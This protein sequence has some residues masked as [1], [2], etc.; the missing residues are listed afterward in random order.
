MPWCAS[1]AWPGRITP[2]PP[3]TIAAMDAVWCGAQNGG[4]VISPDPGGSR[5]ATE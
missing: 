4:V 3:P 1:D 2:V 5:P